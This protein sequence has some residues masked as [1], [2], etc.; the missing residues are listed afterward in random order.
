MLQEDFVAS[1]HMWAVGQILCQIELLWLPMAVE[2]GILQDIC[3]LRL[4]TRF[5]G[6]LSLSWWPWWV[7]ALQTERNW[8]PS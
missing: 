6:L 2:F 1:C 7:I 3:D 8:L 5:D 4:L